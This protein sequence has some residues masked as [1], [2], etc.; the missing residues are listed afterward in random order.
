MK[1]I[2]TINKEVKTINKE[3]DNTYEQ[4]ES[5]VLISMPAILILLTISLYI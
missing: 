1:T 3:F 5:M 2:K 4:I